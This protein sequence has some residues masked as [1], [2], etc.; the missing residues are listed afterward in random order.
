V[1]KFYNLIERYVY[2]VSV[3]KRSEDEKIE[4]EITYRVNS[5]SVDQSF[6]C[7]NDEYAFLPTQMILNLVRDRFPA[8][9]EEK[10]Q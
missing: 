1:G 3:D 8:C 6:H 5:M 7:E 10:F 2:P 9:T 4:D